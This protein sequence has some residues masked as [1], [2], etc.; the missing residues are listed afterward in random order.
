MRDLFMIDPDITF[1]NHGSFGACPTPVFERFIEWQYRVERQPVDFFMNQFHPLMNA[2]RGRLAEFINIPADQ[3]IYVPNATIGLNT[4][5][6]SLNLQAGDEI[7]T[8]DHEYGAMDKMWDFVAQQ[9]GARVI[10]Q[11]LPATMNDP[12]EV[13]NV[14]WDGV[15]DR[16]RV[17]FM[18][19][20]TSPT[21]LILP[22]EELCTRA[23]SAGIISMIDGAH[24]PGQLPLDLTA[25]GADVY[26][27]NCHKW[28]CAPKGAAFLT[29]HP[30]LQAQVEPLI[31]SWGWGEPDDSLVNRNQWQGTRDVC[32]FL[33]VPDAI[34]FQQV[35]D[36]PTI[37]EQC[38]ALA[39][40]A[41]T[42]AVDT[43][44]QTPLSVNSPQWFGQM[45]ALPIPPVS[46]PIAIKKRLIEDYR[47]EIPLTHHAGRD[48][49]R[50]SVQAYNTADDIDALFNALEAIFA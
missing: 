17:L 42:R 7:L 24:V 43:F 9:T 34:D 10:R 50:L 3:L 36:W 32:A 8:T 6:R 35:H 20:I 22:V 16:T 23:R 37:R 26:S 40:A 14:I 13:I 30:D 47:I 11:T 15:T 21:A 49:V 2:S 1:L 5:A 44:G 41:L 12:A 4:V 38:H 45:V 18:S 29:V 48:F 46:D 25:I 19:H 31:I 27:G 28:L 39:S 33:T